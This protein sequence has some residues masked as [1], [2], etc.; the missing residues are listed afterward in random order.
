MRTLQYSVEIAAPPA[1]VWDVML[2]QDTYRDWTSA[3]AEG[4]YF[5]GS[6]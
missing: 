1:T 2:A 5:E 6:W 3:F 4:S